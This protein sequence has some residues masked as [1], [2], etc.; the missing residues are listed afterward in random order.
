MAPALSTEIF[1][2]GARPSSNSARLPPHDDETTLH[3]GSFRKEWAVVLSRICCSTDVDVLGNFFTCMV[4]QQAKPCRRRAPLPTLCHVDKCVPR[5]T[6]SSRPNRCHP[7]DLQQEL[8]LLGVF[9]PTSIWLEDE[10]DEE[11]VGVNINQ[12]RRW[13]TPSSCND[14]CRRGRRAASVVIL[15]HRPSPDVSPPASHVFRN[16]G[17]SAYGTVLS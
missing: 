8:I 5:V 11:V 3:T 12:Q 6:F 14:R 2:G 13:G 1:T 7:R 9:R 15:R 4:R 17:K 16:G 10:D